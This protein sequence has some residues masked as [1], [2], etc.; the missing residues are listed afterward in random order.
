MEDD[1]EH[2]VMRSTWQNT[3]RRIRS[4]DGG[5]LDGDGEDYEIRRRTAKKPEID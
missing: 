5:L 4:G 2:V 1:W 3:H